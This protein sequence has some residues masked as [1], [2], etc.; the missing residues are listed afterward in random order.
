MAN[1]KYNVV[2]LSVAEDL[3]KLV[4][5]EIANVDLSTF[6]LIGARK[7]WSDSA[8]IVADTEGKV[9][10]V[11][12]I[13]AHTIAIGDVLGA[14]SYKGPFFL[15]ANLLLSLSK[16]PKEVTTSQVTLADILAKIAADKA[17]KAVTEPVT[18]VTE[19][20]HSAE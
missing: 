3:T 15:N 17:A 18:E 20:E 12:S 4:A 16:S 9:H 14:L 10:V 19:T 8:E 5:G 1:S 6:K 7:Q 13:N 2:L 11:N